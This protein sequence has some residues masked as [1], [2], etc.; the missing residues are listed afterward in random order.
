MKKF[1]VFTYCDGTQ[2]YEDFMVSAASQDEAWS[3][4]EP[5]FDSS[6]TLLDIQE[7]TE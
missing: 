2:S 6:I 3:K 4:V 5:P 1:K 7:V